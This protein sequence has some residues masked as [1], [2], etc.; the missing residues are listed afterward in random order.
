MKKETA[1]QIQYAFGWFRLF[2]LIAFLLFAYVGIMHG[3][4]TRSEYLPQVHG[5][6]RG[7]YEYQPD[8]E[9]SRFEVRNARLSVDGNISNRSAYKLEVDLYDPA[10]A[11][12]S[13]SPQCGKARRPR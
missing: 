10:V 8:L 13:A 5:I 12:S 2:I 3:Q 9:A 1:K 11:D 7:K 6:L 4:T